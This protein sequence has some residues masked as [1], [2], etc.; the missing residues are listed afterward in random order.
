MILADI[1]KHISGELIGNEST[2]IKGINDIASATDKQLTFV[3]EKKYISTAR[4]SKAS[5]FITFQHID[6]LS[7]QIVVSSPKKALSQTILLFKDKIL[8]SLKNTDNTVASS[9]QIAQNVSM[10]ENCSI[11]NNTIISNFVSIGNHCVIGNN[12]IINPNVTIYDNTVIGD[13]VIIHSGT[14]I[15]T[16]GFGYFLDDKVWNKVPH[17]GYVKIENDVEIGANTCIDRGCIGLTHIMKGCKLDNLV[18]IAHNTIIEPHVAIAAQ[19]GVTGS[20]RIGARVMIGGQAGIDSAYIG[21]N[22]IITA[23]AGV[24]KNIKDNEMVS[25]FPAWTHQKE[26]KKEA[27]LRKKFRSD[28]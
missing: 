23:K 28:L 6:G 14:V 19:V 18:H 12:T 3:L 4:Q 24:T 10:G 2:P 1:A 16:D 9:A 17:V 21:A 26:L 20:T 11:G 8:S 15:G 22:A 27:Y 25:G 7:N 5:A 13:N